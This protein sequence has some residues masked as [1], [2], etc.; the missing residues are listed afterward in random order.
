M[1]VLLRVDASAR[2]DRSITRQLADRFIDGWRET[3]PGVEVL[4]RDVGRKPPAIVTEALIRA[5]FRDS[6]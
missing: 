6:Q 1:T 2:L 4:V 5:G 3:E